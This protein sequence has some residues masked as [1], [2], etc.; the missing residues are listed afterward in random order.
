MGLV[1]RLRVWGELKPVS[2][3]SQNRWV[4]DQVAHLLEAG[5]APDLLRGGLNLLRDA[6]PEG[7]T[8]SGQIEACF[9]VLAAAYP[10]PL[11]EAQVLRAASL[12]TKTTVAPLA[13]SLAY[14]AAGANAVITEQGILL[15]LLSNFGPEC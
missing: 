14:V 4:T 2:V 10:D 12:L 11:M 1:A 6:L 5:S 15:A 3:Q 13:L 8:F 9:S 7:N